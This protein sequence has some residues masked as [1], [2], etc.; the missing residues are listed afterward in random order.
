MFTYVIESEQSDDECATGRGACTP[1]ALQHKG[2]GENDVLAHATRSVRK[3]VAERLEG[4]C[5]VVVAVNPRSDEQVFRGRKE[6][7][8]GEPNISIRVV[9]SNSSSSS[10]SSFPLCTPH[11][12]L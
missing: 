11:S 1:S 8:Y 7:E 12:E 9:S 4:V 2:E 3:R 10:E 5:F 6:F